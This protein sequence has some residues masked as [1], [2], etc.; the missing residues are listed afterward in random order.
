MD[1]TAKHFDLIVVGGGPGGYVAAIRAA[2][3]GFNTALVER[4]ELGGV[5][6][7][8]G[9]IPTKSLLNSAELVGSIDHLSALGAT[10]SNDA[11]AID[12][13]VAKSRAVAGKLSDGISYL[14]AVNGITVIHGEAQLTGKCR[15]S[16]SVDGEQRDYRADHIILATGARARAL[17]A[18]T[19]D[20][21][22]IWS[23]SHAMTP[24]QLPASLVVVGAG[25]IGIEFAS[26]YAQ[27]GSR[28]TVVEMSDRI[29]PA[30]D[31][32]VSAEMYSQLSK[33]GITFLTNASV[34]AASH[35]GSGVNVSVEQNGQ[36]L[37]LEAERILVSA[38]VVANIEQLGLEQHG[39]ELHRGFIKTDGYGKTSLVGTYAIGDV[40][41]PPWLAH[42]AS[43]EAIICVEK[44]A[45]L[46]VKPLNKR[47]IPGCTYC[48]PQ[49]ASIGMTEQQARD[50]GHAVKI[51]SC[52]FSSVGKALAVDHPE[53]FVK[54]VVDAKSGEILGAH[55]VGH[56]VTEQIHSFAVAMTLEATE[57]ELKQVIFAHPTLSEAI[58][59]SLLDCDQKAIHH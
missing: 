36:T 5:C 16:I 19:V 8:W 12:K 20:G 52:R 15:L 44:I 35:V 39:V 37:S 51:G 54:T 10:L 21:D 29:L 1:I 3:L 32:A 27:L 33:R 55:M 31:A 42:K 57:D 6:L 4:A 47:L 9:C 14:M 13:L 2:Q 40:A 46:T 30:E 28:V 11:V 7:N 43:R 17:P 49:V 34:T 26:F 24:G 48:A 53:G 22:R 38:G 59:E 50:A 25:A 23:A 18:A 45:G 58:H 56:G 41:G